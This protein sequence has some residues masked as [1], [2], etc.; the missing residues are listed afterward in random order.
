[1]SD[2]ILVRDDTDCLMPT[3]VHERF[4]DRGYE[5]AVTE[6]I[7]AF[8][9]YVVT[10]VAT[11]MA[12]PFSKAETP[13]KARKA[14][15]Q[16]IDKYDQQTVDELVGECDEIPDKHICPRCEGDGVVDEDQQEVAAKVRELKK[17]VE[18]F[19]NALFLVR[20]RIK[21]LKHQEDYVY[22]DLSDHEES[23]LRGL[24]EANQFFTSAL[25]GGGDADA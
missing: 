13:E 1:M 14:Y 9:G 8:S 5:W 16:G 4:Q 2:K 20:K 6:S 18:Q 7:N 15:S 22:G 3:R 11:G 19:R 10:H 23:F 21:S 25:D 12:V 24:E 17:E